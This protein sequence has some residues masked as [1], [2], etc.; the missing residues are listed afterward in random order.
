MNWN[1]RLQLIPAQRVFMQ[2]QSVLIS[3]QTE[4]GEITLTLERTGGDTLR[5]RVSCPCGRELSADCEI[6]QAA[7]SPRGHAH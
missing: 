3:D 2:S 5:L 7:D 4:P 1:R 6:E